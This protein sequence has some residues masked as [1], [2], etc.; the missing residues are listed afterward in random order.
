MIISIYKRKILPVETVLSAYTHE[1]MHTQA[2]AHTS[3]LTI[4]NLKLTHNLKR[5]EDNDLTQMMIARQVFTFAKRQQRLISGILYLW[6]T[7]TA[8]TYFRYS[9]FM[10]DWDS[11]DWFPEFSIY[12]WLRQQRLISGILYD[13]LRQQQL[14]SGILYLWLTETA[15]TDFRYSLFVY[16][17]RSHHVLSRQATTQLSWRRWRPVYL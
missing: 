4:Q 2:Q 1:H 14:I 7:E 9:L 6:F 3:I 5:A 10:T 15:T 11:N 16:R 8:T 12:D 17:A 13:W